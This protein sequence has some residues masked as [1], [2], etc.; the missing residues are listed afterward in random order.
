MPLPSLIPDTAPLP[1]ATPYLSYTFTLKV[2]DRPRPMELRVW[3]PQTGENLPVILLSHGHGASNYLS[4]IRGYGPLAEFYAAHGF[5]VI[6]VTHL[7]STTLALAP[8]GP[9]GALFWRSRARDI[10]T[11]IDRIAEIAQA[12][13]FLGTRLD[14][15][16]LAVVGHSLGAHTATLLCGAQMSDAHGGEVVDLREPRLKAAVAIA[17]PGK[18]SDL[19]GWASEHFPALKATR[20]DTMTQPALIVVGDADY[21]PLFS[22]RKD[23]RSDA[24]HAAPA[25]KTLAT[26][27]GAQHIFGGI[28]GWDASETSD[29][30]PQRVSD[31]QRLTWAYL[32]SAL[33]PEDTAWVGVSADIAARNVGRTD[34]K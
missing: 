29:E 22:A 30:S 31:V 21:T 5:V 18:G 34:Q 33:Y 13:P 14:S 19:G 27:F 17:P 24:Y 1:Q 2:A 10:S 23:W 11:L 15:T 28:S 3:A 32:R 12:V 4:S 9:E 25:P 7:D 6:Q 16:R 26:L 8:T 20:F